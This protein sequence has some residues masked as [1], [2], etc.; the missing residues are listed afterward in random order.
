VASNSPDHQAAPGH[1]SSTSS[2]PARRLLYLDN[3]R[4]VLIT[5]VVLDHLAMT[6]GFAG[7]WTY[8]EEGQVNPLAFALVVSLQTLG[9]ASLMALFFFVAGYFVPRAYDRRGGWAFVIDRLKRLGIPWLGFLVLILPWLKYATDVHAGKFS[10]SFLDF[11]PVYLRVGVKND[12]PIWFLEALLILSVLYALWRAATARRSASASRPGAPGNLTL[13]LAALAIALCGFVVRI[14]F[15][16]LEFVQPW[17]LEFA[18]APHYIVAFAA[19]II[20]YRG[21][22]LATFPAAQARLWRRVALACVVLLP[23]L[24]LSLGAASGGL[25]ERAAGGLTLQ[26]FYFSVWEAFTCVSMIIATLHWFRSRFDRQGRLA[27]AMAQT[28]FAVYILHPAVIIP[29]CLAL[30][31]V[32]LPLDLK[33]ALVSPVAVTLSYLVAY[34]VRRLPVVRGVL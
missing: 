17:H 20:A 31:S 33:F 22:W 30:S 15:P 9:M 12:G 1:D 28:S 14:W 26:S 16:L 4:T 8:R 6:Y 24:L 23:V 5:L 29:L 11:L 21:D 2:S 3:L 27:A 34:A 13:A 25:D 10:G 32:R 19:G 18:H 7:S